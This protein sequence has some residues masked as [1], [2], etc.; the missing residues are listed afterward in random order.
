VECEIEMKYYEDGPPPL[1][2][3]YKYG[4]WR[5]RIKIY[6][7]STDKV[8]LLSHHSFTRVCLED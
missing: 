3:G 6:V 1:S 8:K 2:E 5:E 7:H 4:R